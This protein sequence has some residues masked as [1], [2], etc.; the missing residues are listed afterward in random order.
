MSHRL[1]PVTGI[2]SAPPRSRD[3]QRTLNLLRPTIEA[4]ENRCL[5]SITAP[6]PANFTAVGSA[7][8][9]INL[10][11]SAV[12]TSKLTG[13]QVLERTFHRTNGGKGSSTGYYT[14]NAVGSTVTATS[15]TLSGLIAG[16]GHNYVVETI[17][18][19]GNSPYSKLVS[20]QTWVAP[21]LS[22]GSAFLLSSGAVYSSPVNV[23]TGLS[24]Q[25]TILVSGNPLT[26]TLQNGPSTASVDA[27][28]GV[29]TYTPSAGETGDVSIAVQVSNPLGSVTQTVPF[30][31]VAT[32]PTLLKPKLK[33]SNTVQ[34]YNGQYHGVS[35]TAVMGDGTVVNG[36]TTFAY[37]GSTGSPL[38]PGTYSV[39]GTFTS[40][41]SLYSGATA[42]GKLVIQK[43]S[44]VFNSISS[45]TF[46]TG[47]TS[48]TITGN[49]SG[50]YSVS[51]SGELVSATF[52]PAPSL[53]GSAGGSNEV[54]TGPVAPS[55][56]WPTVAQYVS[57]DTFGNFSITVPTVNLPVGSYGVTF[58]YA[59]G[60]YFNAAASTRTTLTVVPAVAPQV[61]TN[62]RNVLTTV[63]DVA[64]FTA[65]A[66]GSN[67]PTVQWQVSSDN[68]LTFA[69]LFNATGTTLGF[70]T[71]ANQD[72]Y[73]Y[74]AIFTNQLGSVTTTA[75]KL[76]L[77]ADTGGGA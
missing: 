2:R 70:A 62:P 52:S 56:A 43:A 11:W 35:A 39:L 17:T 60:S 3:G 48:V 22:W 34:T 54:I 77:Q 41:D 26:F 58:G 9:A 49:I 45:P 59:G 63:G 57:V 8:N 37:N 65:A 66:S 16:S 61:T 75:A 31:V 53:A 19:N 18:G 50:N 67:V 1:R 72:G 51:P 29:I 44:P 40:Y 32:D 10:S 46:A 36:G 64:T 25:V 76:T 27:K 38:T 28:T 12:R 30:H 68:G 13:Y 33:L 5:M 14:Y 24:T 4:M 7:A 20:G 21:S 69:N 6:P 23:A 55:A 42:L 74:R 47:T 71:T 73:Y 15:E